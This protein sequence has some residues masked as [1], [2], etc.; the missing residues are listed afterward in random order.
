MAEQD[1][2]PKNET[3]RKPD[4]MDDVNDIS[5][6]DLPRVT[7][8]P[9]SQFAAELEDFK[10]TIPDAVTNFYLNRAGVSINDPRILRLVSLASQK[11]ITDVCNDALQNCKVRIGSSSSKHKTKE[12]RFTLTLEDLSPALSE[13]G[14]TIKKPP[15]YT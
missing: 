6:D 14:I 12:K 5:L 1:Q 2:T 13:N 11:F 10:P 4:P 8:T 3:P 7:G 15:Y 9:L